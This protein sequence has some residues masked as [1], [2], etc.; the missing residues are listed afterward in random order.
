MVVASANN[1]AVENIST[2]I[3]ARQALG[4]Q[5]REDAD[6]FAEQATRLLGGVPAWGA[7][8]ARLGSKKNR[9]EFVNRLWHGKYRLT[10][11]DAPH[12]PDGR[13]P[14]GRD[15]WVDS[16]RGVAH[17]LRG[18]LKTPHAA[19]GDKPGNASTPRSPT[20]SG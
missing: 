20:S 3:P 12:P 19:C 18:Y 15:P 1:G 4:E 11:Q 16:E 17:L 13:R 2:E 9:L 10:D 14:R 5:W 6:Y 8:A 7:V